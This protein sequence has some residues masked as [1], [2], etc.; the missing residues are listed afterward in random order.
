MVKSP[1]IIFGTPLGKFEVRVCHN[2]Y[3]ERAQ[4]DVRWQRK[5][6]LP[7]NVVI[8]ARGLVCT[9]C[10]D[11]IHRDLGSSVNIAGPGER[12]TQGAVGPN[13]ERLRNN[14][15][16]TAKLCKTAIPLFSDSRLALLHVD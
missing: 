4:H 1:W 13:F 6:S 5:K 10:S 2:E 8:P 16:T 12:E 3:K 15:C 11:S 9:P 7:T 14:N